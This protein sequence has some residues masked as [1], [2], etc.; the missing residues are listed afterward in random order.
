MT[1]PRTPDPAADAVGDPT[2]A[3]APPA[4]ASAWASDRP[5]SSEAE[6][7]VVETVKSISRLEESN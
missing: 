5:P 6:R 7:E 2:A 4:P 1:E 3:T